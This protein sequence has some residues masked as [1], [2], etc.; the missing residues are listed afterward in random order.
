MKR[1]KK[2]CETLKGI[3]RDIASAN[4]IDYQPTECTHEGD[5]A[6]SCPACES[7][8]RWLERQ[9]CARHALGKLVTIAGLSV[10]LGALASCGSC[11]PSDVRG[12]VPAIDSGYNAPIVN[13]DIPT[14][15]QDSINGPSI[16]PKDIVN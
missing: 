15:A 14:I 8:T 4:E 6:G 1:G 9:L 7:E 11:K 12:K 5:C 2:I 13:D 10:A 3:R 16:P